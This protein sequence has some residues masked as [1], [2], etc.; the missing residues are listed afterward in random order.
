MNVS[1]A[2]DSIRDLEIAKGWRSLY[3]NFPKVHVFSSFQ[4]RAE[5]R[6]IAKYQ[7]FWGKNKGSTPAKFNIA[8]E[9]WWLEDDP[10]LLGF[11][12]FSGANC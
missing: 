5:T 11:G 10:F 1:I 8:S 4:E 7:S 6:R 9:K 3:P 2:G 12:N